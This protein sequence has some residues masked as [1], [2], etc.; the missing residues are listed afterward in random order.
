MNWRFAALFMLAINVA[1]V[2][3]YSSWGQSTLTVLSVNQSLMDA[4]N[5]PHAVHDAQITVWRTTENGNVTIMVNGLFPHVYER[6]C[7]RV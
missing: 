7:T 5:K 6:M 4:M 1:L 3:V 2:W